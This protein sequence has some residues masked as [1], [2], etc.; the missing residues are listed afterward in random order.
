M[1]I[2]RIYSECRMGFDSNVKYKKDINSATQCFN[3]LIRKFLKEVDVVDKD[4][5]SENITEF[6]DHI[7]NWNEDYEIICRKYPLLIYKSKNKTIAVIDYFIKTFCEY[8]EY[9]ITSENIVLEEIEI[10]D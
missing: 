6:R 8:E 5:F 1:K 9:D 2:Y 3:D 10:L 4:D 7:K